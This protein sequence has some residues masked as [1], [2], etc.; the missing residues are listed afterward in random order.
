MD[1]L[2]ASLGRDGADEFMNLL[3]R[4]KGDYTKWREYLFYGL[5]VE[6]INSEATKLWKKT[7]ISKVVS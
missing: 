6:E 1:A 3:A 2:V 5:S 7:N 4:D